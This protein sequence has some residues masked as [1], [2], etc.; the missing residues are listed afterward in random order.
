MNNSLLVSQELLKVLTSMSTQDELAMIQITSNSPKALI[1]SL[2]GV[3]EVKI[4]KINLGNELEFVT[5][6]LSTLLSLLNK[7]PGVVRFE[8]RSIDKKSEDHIPSI[9]ED[10]LGRDINKKL[11]LINVSNKEWLYLD[12]TEYNIAP[13]DL[14][15]REE[16]L[17]IDCMADFIQFNSILKSGILI[18]NDVVYSQT[19][20]ICVVRKLDTPVG[21]TGVIPKQQLKELGA[22]REVLGTF[23]IRGSKIFVDIKDVGCLQISLN[24]LPMEIPRAKMNPN[25]KD[26]Q[27]INLLDSELP[28]NIKEPV[29]ISNHILSYTR[30]DLQIFPDVEKRKL[31]EL[32]LDKATLTVLHR[33]KGFILFK[34]KKGNV[35]LCAKKSPEGDLITKTLVF[36]MP[37]RY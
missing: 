30:N 25:I 22:L 8:Y 18:E 2:S 5:F 31:K 1:E 17:A 35:L 36:I 21:F 14:K 10:T 6:N 16:A 13:I 11:K 34:H 33:L 27:E 24:V 37:P 20:K 15:S 7:K 19:D 23:Y 3:L 12:Y 4:S 29:I 26:Y 28:R 9:E 32:S